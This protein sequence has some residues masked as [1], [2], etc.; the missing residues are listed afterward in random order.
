MKNYESDLVLLKFDSK[1]FSLNL[2]FVSTFSV[3]KHM[4]NYAS[5]KDCDIV[6]LTLDSRCFFLCDK[7]CNKNLFLYFHILLVLCRPPKQ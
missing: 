5:N 3:V 2:L 7:P 4:C 6:T 1:L